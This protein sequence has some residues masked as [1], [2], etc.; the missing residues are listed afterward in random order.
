MSTWIAIAAVG[1]VSYG[2]R[3]VPLLVLGRVRVSERAERTVGHAGAAALTGLLV[4]ALRHDAAPGS[5]VA[6]VLATVTSLV[7]ARRG[8]SMLRVVFAGSLVYVGLAV[9]GALG[10]ALAG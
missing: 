10:S 3:A 8:A 5:R 9:T 2:F 1:L 6:V 4:G 7:L